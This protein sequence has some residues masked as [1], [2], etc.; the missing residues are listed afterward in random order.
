MYRVV[1]VGACVFASLGAASS[2]DV[3]ATYNKTTVNDAGKIEQMLGAPLNYE[4]YGNAIGYLSS[5][6]SNLTQFGFLLPALSTVD[7]LA[8]T[9][10][11]AGRDKLNATTVH[12]GVGQ[13]H[14][15]VL[16]NT[17]DPQTVTFPSP[18]TTDYLLIEG[19]T[20][21][22]NGD[23]NMGVYEVVV[24]GTAGAAVVNLNREPGV[25]VS[26]VNDSF[27]GPAQAVDGQYRGNQDNS[28]FWSRGGEDKLRVT[29]PAAQ[30]V[31][32]VGL[33]LNTQLSRYQP[34]WFKLNYDGGSETFNLA[35]GLAYGRFVLAAPVTTDFLEVEMPSD[36]ADFYSGSDDNYGVSQFEAF[37]P[38]PATTALLGLGLLG[39]LIRRRS[40]AS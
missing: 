23:P 1:L 26:A 24:N 19:N 10:N 6:G 3:I 17:T 39:L 7:S 8:V 4:G 21:Y 5:S 14:S 34:M 31:A 36:G 11:D 37:V 18:V 15:V 16:D 38:E 28:I 33:H 35:E 30:T 2:A 20:F 9:L 25:A 32:G 22:A 12:Y 29:Y 40:T 27:N 13:S